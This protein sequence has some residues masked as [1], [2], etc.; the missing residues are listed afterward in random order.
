MSGVTAYVFSTRDACGIVESFS[1]RMHEV[2]GSTPV[3]QVTVCLSGRTIPVFCFFVCF[4]MGG[5]GGGGQLTCSAQKLLR[6]WVATPRI[7]K[8][9][10]V[11][12]PIKISYWSGFFP[13][14]L[15][16]ST[17]TDIL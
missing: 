2:L 10:C 16:H 5:G 1:I 9:V 13:I 3:V 7:R 11:L 6:F 12:F 15:I 4:F 14:K 8:K 17:F